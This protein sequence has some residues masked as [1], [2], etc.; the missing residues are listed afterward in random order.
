MQRRILIAED[1]PTQAERLRLL[2]E[3]E[4]YGIDVVAS[5]KEGLARVRSA[6]PDLIISDVVMPVMDGYAFCQAVK[7]SDDTKRIPFVLLTD[8]K[9]PLAIIKGLE[10]GTDN[11]ITKPYEDDYL[12]ERVRRIFENLEHRREGQF[13]V[14]VVVRV[15][16]RKLVLSADKQQIIELLF[17]TLEELGRLNDQLVDAKRVVEEH[18]QNLEMKVQERTRALR[19]SEARFRGLIDA[20]ADAIITVDENQRI[21]LFNQEAERI[22]G[23]TAAE[24][25]GQSL[26]LLLPSR[27]VEMHR[28][29]IPGFAA[30]PETSRRMGSRGEVFGRRK[31]GTEFP[32]EATIFKLRQEEQTILTA[33]LRDITERKSLE[34]QLRQSQKMEAIGSLAGGIAHDFN[35]LLTIINGYSEMLLQTLSPG[36]PSRDNIVQIKEAGERAASL[37]R[38]LLAFS[39]RQVLEPKVLDLNAV[40]TNLDK[41]LQR[42]IGEDIDLVPILKPGLGRVKADPGQI[43]QIIMNLAVNARDA[44]PDG[45][46]LTIE[47][48]NVELDGQ[49]AAQHVAVLP[50]PY[51]MLAV[52]DTGCGMDAETQ[53][54]IFEPFFTTK[55]LGKGTGLGLATVYGIVKQSSGFIW[56]YSEPG[57]GTTFKIY[58]PRVE[59]TAQPIEPHVLL[60]ESLRG[61]ETI[62]L[63]EDQENVRRLVTSILRSSGYTVLEAS[64]G[65]EALHLCDQRPEPIHLLISDVVM[66]IISGRE[67]VQRLAGKYP[68]LKVLFFS[69]YTDDAVVRHGVLEKGTA[70]LQKPFTPTGLLRKVRE[71]LG[72]EQEERS[73]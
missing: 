25:I 1:S 52:S 31:D 44:M 73:R 65:A 38:Q 24:T 17:S 13:E 5:G 42:L 62:L 59:E 72:S 2:L 26:D 46:K 71:V 63:A 7:S 19:S 23:Y 3:D 10:H 47:T 69:G 4:G 64:N 11:F 15:G 58:L 66:P 21:L 57:R 39:R 29:H 48:A 16:S 22:F 61:S 18:A 54:R 70:F 53:K 36:D 40:V 50:G 41:M 27:L 35:N 32:A 8:Q 68:N 9:T 14:E 20:A 37:T 34:T 28:R 43:E 45:G 6:P 12:V 60:N 56:V 33:I 49:Y 67:L 55:E 51:V 30:A